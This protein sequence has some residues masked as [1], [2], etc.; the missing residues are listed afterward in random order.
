MTLTAAGFIGSISPDD[1]IRVRGATAPTNEKKDEIGME[2]SLV[3]NFI[4]ILLLLVNLFLLVIVISEAREERSIARYRR[5]ALESVLRNNGI[6]LAPDVELPEEVPPQLNLKRDPEAEQRLISSLIGR[7]QRVDKG[8]NIYYYEGKNGKAEFRGTGEFYILLDASSMGREATA[9]AKA[10]L[11]KL[12]LEAA[13]PATVSEKGDSLSYLVS[14][15]GIPVHNAQITFD[16]VSSQQLIISG[17]RPLDFRES[18]Q[19]SEFYQDGVTILMS[20][21]EA[22]HEKGYICS[23]I[24][25]LALEYYMY[26]AVSGSSTLSPRW[27]IQ[28]NSGPYFFDAKTGKS[29]SAE[30]FQ[31]AS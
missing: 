3:K 8:G 4:L 18:A 1:R 19:S 5:E 6:E 26:S 21:L 29:E 7:S 17:T 9:M 12:G 13:G 2:K 20:F 11:K 22:V 31:A 16:F 28:T 14:Y 30:A 15:G 24:S 23:E 25:G 27:R 10:Y